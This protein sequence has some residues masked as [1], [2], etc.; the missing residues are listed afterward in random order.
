[1]KAVVVILVLV[2]ALFVVVVIVGAG[3][4]EGG[5]RDAADSGF[6]DELS[7]VLL[8]PAEDV[9]PKE[10]AGL[11]VNGRTLT[12]A[13]ACIAQV[14]ASDAPV[15]EL[16]LEM[17]AGSA[18]ISFSQPEQ[19]NVPGRDV[20]EHEMRT[21]SVFKAGGTLVIRCTSGLSCSLQVTTPEAA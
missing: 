14:D 15:R 18:N 12:V 4:P 11:C 3:K 13:A 10:L 9:T 2:I 8:G 6:V 19:I 7:R 16:S 20:A 21:F 17:L 1:V 5:P